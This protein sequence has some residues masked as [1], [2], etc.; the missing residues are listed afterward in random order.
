M[1]CMEFPEISFIYWDFL[2]IQASQAVFFVT[3]ARLLG[4]PL[5]SIPKRN[6]C[7]SE[8]HQKWGHGG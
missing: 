2:E 3:V 4:Y 6:F 5:P 8:P 1:F 7:C